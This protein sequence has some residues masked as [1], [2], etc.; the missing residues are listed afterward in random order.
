MKFQRKGLSLAEVLVVVGL[1]GILIGLALP[2]IVAVRAASDKTSCQNNLRQV[3]TAL[4]NYE[5]SFGYFPTPPSDEKPPKRKMLGWQ[6][7]IL[8]QLENEDLFKISQEAFVVDPDP[9]HNPPHT[10]AS[11]IIKTYICPSDSRLYSPLTDSGGRTFSFSS[12]IGIAG[13]PGFHGILAGG[14]QVKEVT[15]GLSNTIM[16]SER[17]PPASLQAG[18]WYPGYMAIGPGPTGPNGVIFLGGGLL[19]YPDPCQ[20][21]GTT[22]GPGRLD[23][24]CDRYRLWSLHQGGANFLFGDGSVRFLPYSAEPIMKKLG[25]RNGNEVVEIP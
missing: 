10:P 12:Y 16:V 1:I 25:S 9:S 15:D 18:P 6:G 20:L 4:L 11:A 5:S 13:V 3:G 23:N 8:P 2:A 17:P 14:T 21:D 19:S 22:F 7:W 24:P